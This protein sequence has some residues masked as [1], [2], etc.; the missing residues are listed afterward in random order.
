[1]AATIT[2]I[3]APQNPDTT[4]RQFYVYGTIKLIGNFGS[5]SSNGDT[6]DLTQ[7]GD[8]LK[9]TQLP[10]E[11]DIY[12]TPAAGTAPSFYQFVYCPGTTLKNG[13]L[14]IGSNVT[15]YSQGSAYSAALLAATISFNASF[16][17]Y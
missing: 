5:A 17:A 12:E 13:V 16:P 4:E 2:A 14:S 15:E 6:L 10:T 11:V 8:L 7:L 1:M 9:S 3:I